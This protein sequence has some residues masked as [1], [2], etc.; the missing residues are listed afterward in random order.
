MPADE[1]D[2]PPAAPPAA[3]QRHA[4]PQENKEG[5]SP[6]LGLGHLLPTELTR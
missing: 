5:L 6:V 4:D 2:S 3:A 1:M